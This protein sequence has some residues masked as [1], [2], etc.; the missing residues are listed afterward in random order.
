MRKR[1]R[2]LTAWSWL[3]SCVNI[4][5]RN[6]FVQFWPVRDSRDQNC[7]CE[8]DPICDTKLFWTTFLDRKS[9]PSMLEQFFIRKNYLVNF[10]DEDGDS[11]SKV[12]FIS[13]SSITVFVSSGVSWAITFSSLIMSSFLYI[14][15]KTISFVL[16][17]RKCITIEIGMSHQVPIS[18]ALCLII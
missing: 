7:I 15:L 13:S 1:S 5:F 9:D 12:N 17:S 11:I 8:T 16:E 3:N 6:R 4:W 10:V 14:E 18:T 2:V